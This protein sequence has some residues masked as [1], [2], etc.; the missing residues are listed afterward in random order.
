V[1]AA[2]F[3][4]LFDLVG[5]I[6]ESQSYLFCLMGKKMALSKVAYETVLA[7]R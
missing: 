4:G 5:L 6:P 1:R 7:A 3:L 2:K